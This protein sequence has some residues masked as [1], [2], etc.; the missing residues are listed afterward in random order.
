MTNYNPWTWS[1][2]F[3]PSWKKICLPHYFLHSKI[4]WRLSHLNLVV[5]KLDIPINF[6]GSI[7][8]GFKQPSGLSLRQC[9]VPITTWYSYKQAV[10]KPSVAA[11]TY[12]W[13][14]LHIKCETEVIVDKQHRRDA[15]V[16]NDILLR[17]FTVIGLTNRRDQLIWNA[18]RWYLLDV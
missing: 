15:Y 10:W 6:R 1:L 3:E 8:Q 11:F 7:M 4:H 17:R 2:Q 9:S 18:T 12:V 16:L 13:T 14:A 5:E